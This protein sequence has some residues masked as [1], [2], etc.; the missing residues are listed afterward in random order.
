MALAQ[1]PQAMEKFARLTEPEK[2]TI[3]AQARQADSKEQMQSL[4]RNLAQ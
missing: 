2:E 4:V 1:H 3:L